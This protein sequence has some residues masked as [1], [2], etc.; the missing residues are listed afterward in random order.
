MGRPPKALKDKRSERVLVR[1]TPSEKKLL[2]KAAKRLEV[3]VAQFVR[4]A[5][6]EK[7]FVALSILGSGK[8]R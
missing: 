6:V 8:V 2:V 3:P 7:A 5:S 1:L 4:N